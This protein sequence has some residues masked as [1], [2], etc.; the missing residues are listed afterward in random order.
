MARVH[1]VE[2]TEDELQGLGTPDG[3][4][5][6]PA[7]LR[8]QLEQ[9]CSEH[10]RQ[11]QVR[12]ERL[13][14]EMSKVRLGAAGRN[15]EPAPE[16]GALMACDKGDDKEHSSRMEEL[17]TGLKY[18]LEESV[19]DAMIFT[20]L[21]GMRN[22]SGIVVVLAF[23]LMLFM[24]ICV[25][26][27]LLS[28]GFMDR[29]FTESRR[30]N[31]RR[32]R[33]SEG[34]SVINI[35]PLTGASLVARVCNKDPALSTA[36]SQQGVLENIF[37][38]NNNGGPLLC[39]VACILWTMCIATELRKAINFLLALSALPR[40]HRS[41][42]SGSPE[43][44]FSF[45]YISWTRLFFT[46][47][48]VLMRMS[49][50][51]MLLVPGTVWLMY[52]TS[53]QNLLLNASALGFVLEIDEI[54]FA[55]VA[56]IRCSQLVRSM[57]ALKLPSSRKLVLV[58]IC[59][60]ILVV[61]YLCSMSFNFMLVNMDDMDKANTTLC[62]GLVN[63]TASKDQ[64]G[65]VIFAATPEYGNF[66]E[67]VTVRQTAIQGVSLGDTRAVEEF[68]TTDIL[69]ARMVSDVFTIAQGTSCE[70]NDATIGYILWAV[71]GNETMKS[72]TSCSQLKNYCHLDSQVAQNVRVSCPVTCGCND[73]KS[74]LLGYSHSHEGCPEMR[75]Q[76]DKSYM[77]AFM[78][79]ECTDLT[80]A[81]LQQSE[82]WSR[83]MEIFRRTDH[84]YNDTEDQ[85]LVDGGCDGLLE[86]SDRTKW[87]LC[88][89]S[90]GG[91]AS[92]L[93]PE[94]CDCPVPPGQDPAEYCA[95]DCR[96]QMQQGPGQ[97]GSQGPGGGSGPP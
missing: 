43:Q 5:P 83:L 51:C 48:V 40:Q 86:V 1:A 22:I 67:M 17:D 27:I 55:T 96:M 16:P 9:L 53:I 70:D 30:S 7:A 28:G 61:A 26:Y 42:L 66:S 6:L 14:E 39:I 71:T 3:E 4:A 25:F 54:I 77:D 82:G 87:Y 50:A 33:D 95:D 45:S 69:Q 32:W 24:Q 68:G 23:G 63:F 34:H 20:G 15:Y 74:G 35:D 80:L 73:P 81:E 78:A 84:M 60:L 94:S 58:P 18:S 31:L 91:G 93:C 89:E 38:Y 11:L 47:S 12:I 72:I 49:L 57:H 64:L 41:Q 97:G 76:N 8:R 62:S 92:T 2:D 10:C 13:E 46:S 65:R 21:P 85:W 52:E 37:S 56:P 19:W 75:C 44:G 90:D 79:L 88:A 36:T 29:R 59:M